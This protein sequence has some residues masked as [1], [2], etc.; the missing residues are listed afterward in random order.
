MAAAV[1]AERQTI[2][3][4]LA[5]YRQRKKMAFIPFIT[6]GD[7]DLDATA[8]ALKRLDAAGAAVIEL[9]VPYSD[10]LA[11]GPVIQSASNRA[12]NAGTTLDGVLG[13]LAG[14]SPQLR[15]PVV[16]F[17]YYNPI[18]ARG[19]DQFCAQAR[20]AGASGLLVPDL[21]LEETDLIREA[22]GGA[23]LELVLLS[24]PTTPIERAKRI[25]EASQGFVYL[26]SVA[27]VTGARVKTESR[28]EGLIKAVREV[29]DKPVCVGFG[30]SGPDQVRELAAWH[31]DGVIVGSALVRALGEAPSKEEGLEALSKLAE[32]IASAC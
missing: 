14:V 24:T 31:A 6:A 27:G 21:P 3:D 15:A 18:M 9:G 26:V 11:D 12:L 25:A 29:T 28:V 2:S 20:D 22:A 16:M 19:A 32:S 5:E 4:R 10:P 30:V 13:M 8:E 23:G 17:T 1:A 7:P